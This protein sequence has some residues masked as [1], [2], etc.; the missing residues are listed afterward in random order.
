MLPTL[1][2][3]QYMVNFNQSQVHNA[4][5]SRKMV[6]EPLPLRVS[7]LKTL[8]HCLCI[9]SLNINFCTIIFPFLLLFMLFDV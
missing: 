6:V 3:Y 2:T 1:R 4:E 7:F 8:I 5:A 9:T